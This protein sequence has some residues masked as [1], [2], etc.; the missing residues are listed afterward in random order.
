MN[1]LQL[2]E[3]HGLLENLEGIRGQWEF[4][5][6]TLQRIH[7]LLRRYEVASVT[8][9]ESWGGMADLL[10]RKLY[11]NAGIFFDGN[12]SERDDI[13]LHEVAH[14]YEWEASR[15]WIPYGINTDRDDHGE[16]WT[17]YALAIGCS[18]RPEHNLPRT[19]TTDRRLY[20][21]CCLKR[22][23]QSEVDYLYKIPKWFKKGPQSRVCNYCEAPYVRLRSHDRK[24]IKRT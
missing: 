6:Y 14:V 22:C 19:V 10:E 3:Q 15:L 23:E 2:L 16:D 7:S 24:A 5:D 21:F 18:A 20:A 11:F 1:G 8:E 12:E 9:R 13:L 17:R 4:A